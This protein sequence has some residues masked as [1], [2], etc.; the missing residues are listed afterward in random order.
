MRLLKAHPLAIVAALILMAPTAFARDC[1]Y[2]GANYAKCELD[3]NE[4]LQEEQEA[5]ACLAQTVRWGPSNRCRANVPQMGAGL[6]QR[7]TSAGGSTGEADVTCNLEGQLRLSNQNCEESCVSRNIAW[8]PSDVCGAP[9]PTLAN[10]ESIVLRHFGPIDFTGRAT[11][12]CS[13]G[14]MTLSSIECRQ[15][16]QAVIPDTEDVAPGG[17]LGSGSRDYS[18]EGTEMT[19]CNGAADRGIA[20]CDPEPAAGA[21]VA[22][23]TAQFDSTRSPSTPTEPDSVCGDGVCE[24]GEDVSCPADCGIAGICGPADGQT[25]Q[26]PPSAAQACATGSYLPTEETPRDFNWL[27]LSSG[28]QTNASCSARRGL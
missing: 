23:G 15:V 28:T 18:Y 22:P 5:E 9:A 1:D 16:G 13:A 8:G 2:V 12:T 14:A 25:L 20:A 11:V 10:G 7:F 27:C 6:T 3:T 26:S 21:Q 17:A 19:K 24:D 4:S